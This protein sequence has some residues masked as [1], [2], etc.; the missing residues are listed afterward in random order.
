MLLR[1]HITNEPHLQ[2]PPVT[3]TP[4]HPTIISPPP[5][6]PTPPPAAPADDP[7]RQP[8]PLTGEPHRPTV[9]MV[10]FPNVGKS[11]TINALFGGKKVAVAPTPGKTKHFQ[12][13]LV[14][15]DLA[16]CDW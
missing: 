2:L 3:P 11:S 13:L 12:T 5:S 15:D 16:L 6:P 8:H 10:G 7:R 14:T 4:S 9:G 1:Y